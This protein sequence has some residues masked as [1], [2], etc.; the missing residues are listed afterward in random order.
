MYLL[1]LVDYVYISNDQAT[2]SSPGGRAFQNFSSFGI[3]VKTNM[4]DATL[5]T[6][7]VKGTGN[8]TRTLLRRLNEPGPPEGNRV[9]FRDQHGM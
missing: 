7:G 6:R 3:V 2:G 9:Q 1:N 4:A 8:V 5:E